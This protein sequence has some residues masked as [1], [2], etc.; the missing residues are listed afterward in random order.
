VSRRLLFTY[1]SL[2]VVVLA[3]LEIPL[4]VVNARSEKRDLSAKVERD[5]VAVASLSE[6]TVEHERP[7]DLRPVRALAIRYAHDTGGRVVIVDRKGLELVDTSPPAPGRR[8][9]SS[10][11][12]F[13]AALKGD[14]ATGT[15]HS[16]T[17][18][19]TFLYVA[20]PIASGGRVLGA[21]R[22]SY[23]TSTLDARTRRYWFVLA[24]IAGV[25]LAVA[26]LLGASFARWIRG[27][28]GG[29]EHA[30]TQVSAGDLAARA[31]VPD[32]PP[33][34]R[35]LTVQFNEMVVK[36]DGLVR[37][38]RDFVADASHELRT[39]LTALRLRLENLE[40]DVAVAGR[41][42]LDAALTEIERLS[43]I[44]ESLLAL[45]RADS[46]STPPVTIDAAA[47][48]SERVE[49][50]RTVAGERRV[51][52]SFAGN[53]PQPARASADRVAQVLDNL[54]SNALDASPAASDVTV[55]VAT[56]GAIVELR[57]RDRGPGL[58]AEQRARAFDRFWRAGTGGGGSG[59]GLAIAR[60]LV[61]A[62][63]GT[64]ELCEATGGGLEA[65]VRLPAG[66]R[67]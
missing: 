12:E 35:A 1:L 9:F 25:V 45:A 23:P 37:S 20:V 2:A 55:S 67:F 33:E 30:A 5:A 62:D 26:G 15:R 56:S 43:G 65:V 41:P 66:H 39:P 27:P 3:A 42:T 50:W 17:L 53:G 38:Q 49:I 63:G 36:L 6:S 14:V 16:A 59:L 32:G 46:G 29:L 22:V 8:S 61:E 51:G 54:L 10:R 40:R 11:P 28:L 19:A 34:L 21:V 44:V 18:G 48:A 57:V 7:A 58:S 24:G 64:I 4:G 60:R 47:V 31:S 52:L 13:A